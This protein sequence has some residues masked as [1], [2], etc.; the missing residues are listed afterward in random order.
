[1]IKHVV[2][3]VTKIVLTI[4]V[5]ILVLSSC[6]HGGHG[7]HLIINLIGAGLVFFIL[8]AIQI[9]ERGD[10]G[11]G[12]PKKP[13]DGEE[14]SKQDNTQS[15]E[16]YNG[17]LV[18]TKLTLTIFLAMLVLHMYRLHSW[19]RSEILTV[20]YIGV[21]ILVVLLV[22]V[23]IYEGKQKQKIKALRKEINSEQSEENKDDEE[24]KPKQDNTQL[25]KKE[26]QKQ[27]GEEYNGA[28]V[29]IKLILTI[30][31]VFMLL[32]IYIRYH[33]WRDEILTVHYIVVA[34]LVVLLVAVTIYE[35][36]Q[37]KK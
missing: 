15:E 35:I 12:A 24:E 18:V 1:M 34:I 27:E 25:E 33:D 22:A 21:A 8:K 6:N 37:K 28:F 16:E 5:I 30:S 17:A 26:N 9:S 13:Q 11:L 31:L 36:K 20:H 3:A 32:H 29:L 19:F 10:A 14:K 4:L 23:I 2:M 7:G